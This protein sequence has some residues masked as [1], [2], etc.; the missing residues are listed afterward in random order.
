[1][2]TTNPGGAG[3]W[4]DALSECL[5][6]T[7]VFIV[8]D[9]D[10]PG[11]AHALTVARSLQVAGAKV[12]WR[13][14]KEG[15]DLADHLDAGFGLHDLVKEKPKQKREP[16]K[17]KAPEG[18]RDG[19]ALPAMYQLIVAKL[20]EHAE[21]AGL[22]APR[23]HPERQGFEVCCPAH[24]DRNPSL[25]IWLGDERAVVLHCQAGCEPKAIVNAL[26]IDWAEFATADRIIG[27]QDDVLQEVYEAMAI[28]E[29][30]DAQP[31][32]PTIDLKELFALPEPSWLIDGYFPAKGITVIY[33]PEGV[34]K[35]LIGGSVALAVATG[36]EW[37]EQRLQPEGG[38]PMLFYAGEG[39]QGLA[40]RW[41]AWLRAFAPKI[42]GKAVEEWDFAPI[43]V[44][45]D[46]VNL[47]SEEEI[48]RVIRS[49]RE[50]EDSYGQPVALVVFDSFIEFLS[51]DNE[52][53]SLDKASRAA[54]VIAQLL[55]CCVL[56][57][58]HPNAEGRDRG[59]RHLSFRAHARFR[60]ERWKDNETWLVAEK[61]RDGEL[62][63]MEF[64]LTPTEDSVL[65]QRSRE[66]PA[67]MF[68][69]EKAE[70]V[71]GGREAKRAQRSAAQDEEVEK[72][73]LAILPAA[74]ESA[75]TQRTVIRDV[76]GF[77]TGKVRDALERL[78]EQGSICKEKEGNSMHYW[79]EEAS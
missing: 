21:R 31:T 76:D 13:R 36:S 60:M 50:V 49:A 48:A 5:A 79:R 11:R 78:V 18:E 33:G 47:D 63:A 68:E 51:G 70:A 77:G 22:P 23:S 39:P 14:A 28:T 64:D 52:K 1:M 73:V 25:G 7:E 17:P 37:Y 20:K 35:T 67:E 6:G 2:G 26:G 66:L 74:Q 40:P 56:I 57:G 53:E 30:Q 42:A 24:D 3:K 46:P 61:Q 34:G 41:M 29:R 15:K 19:S 44:N 58:H 10:D 8:W 43:R 54:R 69:R 45:P 62:R 4:S 71:E 55:G 9:R 27:P 72:A 16:R 38:A 32:H 65:L 75:M 12:R 59:T